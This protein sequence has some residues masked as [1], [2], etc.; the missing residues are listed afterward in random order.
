MARVNKKAEACDSS[1]C[2]SFVTVVLGV[3]AAVLLLVGG[4]TIWYANDGNRYSSMPWPKVCD[5]MDD[6]MDASVC[7]N[8][9]STIIANQRL[10]LD[11][12]G[13]I[14][15]S[16]SVIVFAILMTRQKK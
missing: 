8:V 2:Q 14:G 13:A 1:R 9:N 10:G 16:T 11:I 6:N 7:R 3:I 5:E 4:A 12:L 15:I